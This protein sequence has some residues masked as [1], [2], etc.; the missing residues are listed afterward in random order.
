MSRAGETGEAPAGLAM[1]AAAAQAFGV[2]DGGLAAEL[3]AMGGET[4]E[5]TAARRAQQD[6]DLKASRR[7]MKQ[8]KK[9]GLP[10][11]SLTSTAFG[12]VAPG[13][14]VPDGVPPNFALKQAA[15]LEFTGRR[16]TSGLKRLGNMKGEGAYRAY[17]EDLA[18]PDRG[19]WLGFFDHPGNSEQAEHTCGILGT[20]ATVLR[21]RGT[22]DVCRD[23][24]DMEA[25]VLQRYE[26]SCA[27]EGQNPAQMECKDHLRYKYEL[28]RFNLC[29]QTR[30]LDECAELFFSLAGHELKYDYSFDAQH[31][32]FM[33][34]AVLKKRPTAK[35]LRSLSHA[36]VRNMLTECIAFEGGVDVGLETAVTSQRVALRACAA[37]GQEEAALGTYSKCSGCK[38][39]HYCSKA[40]QKGHWQA[41]KAA[42]KA[43]KRAACKEARK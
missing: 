7:A 37:C 1:P 2:I 33:V 11:M 13:L 32:L 40:C 4:D 25:Q 30:R 17:Y 15:Y 29:S 3:V 31:F 24:L 42:C 14:P 39:V 23:V 35:T 34:A 19:L 26:A 10:I 9:S 38:Q 28:I 6:V 5:A 21:Q 18:G 20:L 27:P 16:P 12:L 43:A 41:H 22:F 36:E 8:A